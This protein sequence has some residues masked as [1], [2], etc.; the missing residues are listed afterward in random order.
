MRANEVLSSFLTVTSAVRQRCSIPQFLFNFAI[1]D[2]FQS[3]LQNANDC[4]VRNRVIDSER[5]NHIA[6]LEDNFQAIQNLFNRSV[7]STAWS[8]LCSK[9]SKCQVHFGIGRS[10]C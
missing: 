1:E 9:P 3:A 7:I 8:D 5:Y 2:L 4:S 10:L 6:F